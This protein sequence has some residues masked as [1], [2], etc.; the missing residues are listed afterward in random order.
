MKKFSLLL[1]LVVAVLF[2][3]SCKKDDPTAIVTPD[4]D[5]KPTLFETILGKWTA[6]TPDGRKKTANVSG[7][8]QGLPHFVSIEFLSDSTYLLEMEG[9]HIFEGRFSPSD[10]TVID[11]RQFGVL[12]D[13]KFSGSVISFNLQTVNWGEF[14]VTAG[15]SEEVTAGEQTDL[16][17][18]VWE[19]STPAIGPAIFDRYGGDGYMHLKL[20]FS[21]SG[22]YFIKQ[23]ALDTLEFA[24]TSTWRWHPSKANTFIYQ[25]KGKDKEV[26]I[27][28]LTQS[29]LKIEEEITLIQYHD[30]NGN[31]VPGG[32]EVS[33]TNAYKFAAVSK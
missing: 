27:K 12:S 2:T 19:M 6:N 1:L 20:S 4:P 7:K 8:N 13:I 17:C 22:T 26:T 23:Y 5:P 24:Q 3:S 30:A 33:D 15:K 14:V 31:P 29:A 9:N 10:S 16:L 11:L 18:R 25:Y 32:V 21:K 28:Q